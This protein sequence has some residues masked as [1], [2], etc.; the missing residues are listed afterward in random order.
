M[1]LALDP[2][3]PSPRDGTPPAV[4]L[5]ERPSY[6]RLPTFSRLPAAKHCVFPYTAHSPEWPV[7][8]P[9]A[10][11]G[12]GNAVS[13][14]AEGLAIWGDAPLEEIAA[15]EGL[16]PAEVT[17]LKVMAEHLRELLESEADDQWRCAETAL[18]YD[19]DTGTAR[20]LVQEHR[21]DYSDRKPGEKVGTPD[22]VRM[23]ADGV[24]VVRDYKTG[25][26]QWGA[27]PLYS[28]QLRA[29][30]LAAARAYGAHEVVVE[31]VQVDED[32]LRIKRETLDPFELA[33]CAHEL[34]G[35]RARIAGPPEAPNP[36]PWCTVRYCPIR[37]V[38]PATQSALEAIDRA[39]KLEHPVTGPD[40][41]PLSVTIT[42]PEHASYTLGR[43]KA[44]EAA[45]ATIL[46]A[47][48]DY[49]RENGPVP[50]GE[51]KRWG[52]VQCDGRERIDLSVEGA[53]ALIERKLGA[54]A[55]AAAIESKTSKSALTAA[56]KA[57][58][59][60]RGDGVRAVR[61]LL[62]ELRELGALKQAAPFEK[63]EAFP[64][65]REA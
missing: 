41:H 48:K 65:P 55:A 43:L 54:F 58:Q 57:E 21:R 33:S 46:Q 3:S 59:E 35:I 45:V 60:K 11:K 38:C 30:G 37:A 1:T 34:R 28:A 39:S 62:E 26:Y 32:K 13:S 16:T 36:G 8:P 49:V 63:F 25:R 61:A 17:K 6:M 12:L 10:F 50:Y 23:T 14:V 18:A 42:S 53:R 47:V 19:L 31:F 27:N 64:A 4:S 15:E 52:A 29:L 51:G 5:V 2:A 40:T 56:A 20:E 22:L 44:V 9:N 7:D 24:L